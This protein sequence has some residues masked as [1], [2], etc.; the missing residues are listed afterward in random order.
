MVP[1]QAEG[2]RSVSASV[3][4]LQ[5]HVD[6]ILE[7][8]CARIQSGQMVFHFDNYVLVGVDYGFKL[9]RKRDAQGPFARDPLDSGNR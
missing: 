2:S 5:P 7:L 3:Q 9:R 1:W 4:E 8:L 6:K